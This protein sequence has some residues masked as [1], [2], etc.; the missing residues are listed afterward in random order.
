MVDR[1]IGWSRQNWFYLLLPLWLA[2]A[3]GSRTAL[4]WTK[5]PQLAEAATLFDWCLFMP[6][7]FAFCYRDMPSR[8][9]VIRTLAIACGGLWFA[10]KIVPYS[11][12][13][14]LHDYGWLREFG[15]GVL[16][17]FEILAAGAVLRV[18]SGSAPDPSDLEK[19]GVPPLLISLILAEAR[20]WR[21]IWGCLR[22]R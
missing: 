10:G 9:L 13:T 5:Q 17:I 22:G 11:A 2:A 12:Q 20:F 14:I 8:V 3:L 15:L 1:I 6:A 16:A 18:L 19:H 21:W 4:P 7:L